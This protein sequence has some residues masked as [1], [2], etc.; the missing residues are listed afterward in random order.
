MPIGPL[1]IGN[2]LPVTA[3]SH[4]S[5]SSSLPEYLRP[6]AS[7]NPKFATHY[8]GDVRLRT[9]LE[10]NKD[11]LGPVQP[12]AGT[13][14]TEVEWE[15]WSHGLVLKAIRDLDY[16]IT[17]A[18]TGDGSRVRIPVAGGQE[19]ALPGRIVYLGRTD[20][21]VLV[22]CN[23]DSFGGE[24]YR[25]T[26][27]VESRPG[28]PIEMFYW[29]GQPNEQGQFHPYQTGWPNV[30]GGAYNG[31]DVKI[32]GNGARIFVPSAP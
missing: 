9:F 29:R 15:A 8:D 2:R 25:K 26:F 11:T 17:V 31:R 1:R 6:L 13:V 30:L 10:L 5:V 18:N 19:K 3:T 4:A 22:P 20:D 24:T 21:H 14:T 27:K 7:V 12:K 28:E 23:V 16:D 32:I